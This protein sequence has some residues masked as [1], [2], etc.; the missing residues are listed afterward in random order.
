MSAFSWYAPN[1]IFRSAIPLTWSTRKCLLSSCRS[2]CIQPIPDH[3]LYYE[4][5]TSYSIHWLLLFP[6]AFASLQYICCTTPHIHTLV[7]ALCSLHPLNSL[8]LTHSSHTL[9]TVSISLCP[10]SLSRNHSY[11]L[12]R[13]RDHI[14]LDWLLFPPGFTTV[15]LCLTFRYAS[16]I[17]PNYGWSYYIIP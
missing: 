10:Y 17:F 6:S 14:P 4:P 15:R 3:S 16:S 8:K 2:P 7:H 12:H 5:F 13:T 1:K 9:W 11:M